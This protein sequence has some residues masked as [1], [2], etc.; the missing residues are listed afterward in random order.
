MLIHVR[1]ALCD[2]SEL[3]DVSL[4]NILSVHMVN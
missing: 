1:V 2:I 3:I 4:S